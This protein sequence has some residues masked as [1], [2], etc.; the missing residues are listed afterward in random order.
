MPPSGGREEGREPGREGGAA[1]SQPCQSC[2]T[3]KQ[4]SGV[5]RPQMEQEETNSE[6]KVCLRAENI[7]RIMTRD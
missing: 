4:Q 6:G 3:L 2:C 1:E 7:R 5:K